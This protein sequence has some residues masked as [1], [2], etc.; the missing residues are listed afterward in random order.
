METIQTLIPLLFGC[1]GVYFI[2]RTI[3]DKY[4]DIK[5]IDNKITDETEHTSDLK[6]FSYVYRNMLVNFGTDFNY[7]KFYFSENEIYLYCRNTYPTNIYKGPFILKYNDENN[8]SYFSKFLVT[9]FML[10]GNDLKIQ[11]RNKHLLGTKLTLNIV[12]ISARDKHILTD[13]FK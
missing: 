11:F 3:F 10:N 12:G 1:V 4:K 6:I 5:N 13:K 8:Y 7:C 9:K 2:G